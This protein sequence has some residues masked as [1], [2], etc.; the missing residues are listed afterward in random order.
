MLV[1]DAESCGPTGCLASDPQN[2]TFV[3]QGGTSY[4][5]VIDA[6]EGIA[7]SYTL[8]MTCATPEVCDNDFDDD[9][10]GL[11]GRVGNHEVRH[12]AA[13]YLVHDEPG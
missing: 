3:A 8:T 13:G 9:Q 1:G 5:V 2:L 12:R 7:G 10:D 6:P 4:A 11:V